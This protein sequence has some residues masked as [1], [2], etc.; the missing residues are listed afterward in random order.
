MPA[1]ETLGVPVNRAA[2]AVA[3][4]DAWTNLIQPFWTLPLLAI[5]GLSIR[6]I[7]GY[8]TVALLWTGLVIMTCMALLY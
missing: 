2:M 3:L 4:G 5:A 6:D 7:M 8:C 1:A